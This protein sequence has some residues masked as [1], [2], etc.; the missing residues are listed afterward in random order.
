MAR[1][2]TDYVQYKIRVRELDRREIEAAAK[3]AGHSINREIINRIGMHER[4]KAQ[5]TL[6]EIAQDMKIAWLRYELRGQLMGTAEQLLAA[7]EQMKELPAAVSEAADNVRAAIREIEDVS[8]PRRPT[9][10]G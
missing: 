1:K 4:L 10:A 9:G 3:K 5:Q 8:T 7:I 6:W 2:Q